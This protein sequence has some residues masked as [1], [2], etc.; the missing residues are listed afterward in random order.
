MKFLWLLLVSVVLL[1]LIWQRGVLERSGK[2]MK[3]LPISDSKKLSLTRQAP[4]IAGGIAWFNSQPLSL[5]DLQRKVVLVDFW[6]YSCVNCQR[7]LPFLRQWWE[8]YKDKGLVIIGVH[9]PEF[10]FE[11]DRESVR[12][13][14]NRYEV[15]WPVVMDNDY[16]IWNA[17]KNH[18]WPH[19][20]LVDQSGVIVY[21]HIG[22]GAYVETE[23]QIQR[24]LGVED[25]VVV[26][27]SQFVSFRSRRTQEL[28]VNNR[29][30]SSG[31]IGIG[32][33]R[34]ELAGNWKVG[35]GFSSAGKGAKLN[36]SFEAGEVNLVMSIPDEVKRA[37]EIMVDNEK[38][39]TINIKDDDLYKI[40]KGEF[41]RH[42]LRM[43]VEEG[44]RV[45]AF[46]FGD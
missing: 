35:D 34:V 14:L 9:T 23:E 22:E 10:E 33:D 40:W 38:K 21:D 12:K 5:E 3:F 13:A 37:V 43:I 18:F 7:T 44:I 30:I 36:L 29:G 27:D 17:Y 4:E 26:S 1:S 28:Y 6:T 15:S 20:Y 45:H 41:G 16:K 2:E 42:E 8:K 19:K 32:Q 39:N 46:T 11:K 31:Q 25:I 24:L